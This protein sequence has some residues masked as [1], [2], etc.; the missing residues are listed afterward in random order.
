[1]HRFDFFLR[2]ILCC[3]S[4][5]GFGCFR[6]QKAR[7]A[8][9]P[10]FCT[11]CSLVQFVQHIT[12]C[13]MG[14][15]GRAREETDITKHTF[16]I[17]WLYVILLTCI[18]VHLHRTHT[19]PKIPHCHTHPTTQPNPPFTTLPNPPDADQC[20]ELCT[21]CGSCS[22][23]HQGLHPSTVSFTATGLNRDSACTPMPHAP[24][25]HASCR[26]TNSIAAHHT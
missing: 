13:H 6:Q 14:Y 11:G 9:I 3:I 5:S 21:T 19:N 16:L 26:E 4:S 17:P 24:E 8:R 2:S 25:S 10:L 20:L 22:S 15:H 7:G 12:W 1:M 18:H 23:P